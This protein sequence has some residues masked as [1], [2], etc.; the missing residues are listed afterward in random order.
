MKSLQEI[1]L[2]RINK[3]V[4]IF[5]FLAFSNLLGSMT[6][7]SNSV[8]SL[9]DIPILTND[10]RRWYIPAD[11]WP[12]YQTYDLKGSF[13]AIEL[14]NKFLTLYNDMNFTDVMFDEFTCNGIRKNQKLLCLR[15][16]LSPNVQVDKYAECKFMSCEI[17]QETKTFRKY[18][19]FDSALI[20]P[21][22][23]GNLE[24]IKCPYEFFCSTSSSELTTFKPNTLYFK[25]NKMDK[26]RGFL[27]IEVNGIPKFID[28]R[29]CSND[30]GPKCYKVEIPFSQYEEQWI[31]LKKHQKNKDVSQLNDLIKYL[32][33]CVQRKDISCVKRYFI[34]S[35]DVDP[36]IS[37]TK[38]DFLKIFDEN[39]LAELTECL[40]YENLLPHLMGTKGINKVC[41]FNNNL[42][43]A[44]K[45]PPKGTSK[46]L[47]VVYPEAVRRNKENDHILNV[48]LKE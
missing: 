18:I 5:I 40:K 23:K 10:L 32:L 34:S 36:S 25:S 46:L 2:N 38:I 6:N 45:M 9:K 30:Q 26:K 17:K 27:Q 44:S 41:V 28:I 21:G 14:K 13:Y 33:P 19:Y 29:K 16:Y 1:S 20:K 4:L 43:P 31:E 47:T 37:E 12:E 7:F 15:S 11:V 39:L 42:F 8:D 48:E 3:I 35:M 24:D 22:L